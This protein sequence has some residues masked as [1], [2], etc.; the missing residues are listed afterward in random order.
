MSEMSDLNIAA[1]EFMELVANKLKG[2]G[3]FLTVREVE[4]TLSEAR[5]KLTV[6]DDKYGNTY[7]FGVSRPMFLYERDQAAENIAR[8]LH[9]RFHNDLDFFNAE[10]AY[11]AL[12]NE[13]KAT[14]NTACLERH[15][16]LESFEKTLATELYE[17]GLFDGY[18][19]GGMS[20]GYMII[21]KSV[22]MR[23]WSNLKNK[24]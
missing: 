22:T 5:Y 6:T 3:L 1:Y 12:S 16:E 24:K 14:F 21:P 13:A 8:N 15:I 4:A 2:H 17:S 11:K 18:A 20:Y 19:D 9:Y 7:E 10:E 23:L